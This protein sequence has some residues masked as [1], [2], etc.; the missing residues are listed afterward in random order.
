MLR[1]STCGSPE[2]KRSGL[3]GARR[4]FPAAVALIVGAMVVA[5]SSAPAGPPVATAAPSPVATS[6]ATTSD[7]SPIAT[8]AA[9]TIAPTA[10]PLG[11]HVIAEWT[12]NSP[13]G[14]FIGSNS[15]W[16]PGHGDGKTTRINPS[17]N[18]VI[19][20]M[21]AESGETWPL[22]EGFGSLWTATRD[23]KLNRVDPATNEIIA[24]IVL[25][26]G[27]QD[28]GNG[29]VISREAVWVVQNDNAEL[30]KIDPT[31]NRVVSMTGF[32]T[33]I[34]EAKATTS[35]PAGNGTDFMWLQIVGDEG[36]G[37]GITKG[38]LRLDPNSGAGLTFLPWGRDQDGD[39]ALSVADEAVWYGAGGQIY[40]I[41]VDDNAIDAAYPTEPGIIHLGIGFGSIWLVNYERS[42]VQRLDVPL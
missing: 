30:I 3:R 40:R 41:S 24:S 29:V 5:C 10:N 13:A 39:G 37:A 7:P 4:L 9:A 12:V 15:V 23:N 22:A 31:T 25:D 14:I 35:V 27:Y 26:D 36:G 19:S 38:L 34:D 17:S 11:E 16:V 2:S 1:S 42:L 18:E 32:S 28:I 20:V 8:S 21:S 6:V 33:L